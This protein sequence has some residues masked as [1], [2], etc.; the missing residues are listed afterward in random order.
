MQGAD[1]HGALASLDQVAG[2]AGVE[3][4]AV[5]PHPGVVG[6]GAFELVAGERRPMTVTSSRS[7]RM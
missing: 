6:E 5:H 3:Q 1:G 7:S 2:A 4:A